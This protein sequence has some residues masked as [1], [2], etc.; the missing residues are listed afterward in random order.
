MSERTNNITDE[1]ITET[2]DR[3][4]AQHA[5]IT[6]T[7]AGQEVCGYPTGF[8]NIMEHAFL[9]R[10]SGLP[11][12]KDDYLNVYRTAQEKMGVDFI[13]QWIPDNPLTMQEDGYRDTELTAT[14]GAQQIVLDGMEIAGPEDVCDHMEKFYFPR[15]RAAIAAFDESARIRE[16]G[17]GEYLQ[18]QQMGEA[19]LKTGYSFVHFPTFHYTE[20]GYENYFCAYALEPA[21]MEQAFTLEADLAR[22]NNRAAAKAYERYHLPKLYRLDHDMT[23]SRGTLVNIRSMETLWFPQLYRALEPMLKTD[24]TMIWHCDGNIMP[25]IPYLLDCGIRGFQG[26]QYEDGVDFAKLCSLKAKDNTP[27]FI[28]GGSSVT[29]TLP[30]GTPEDVRK[31]LRYLVE[32]HGNSRLALGCSSSV[33]PGVPWENIQT[34]LEGLAYYRTHLS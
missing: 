25:M 23:D 5:R 20:Y 1:L 4:N 26:F 19:F 34:L 21:L 33:A 22:L 12:Y 30:M 7:I 18:Q 11:R 27:L 15:L 8:M 32:N 29:R 3:L 9:E 24:V 16:I 28:W 17:L 6:D 2:F 14:T 31:E 10:I 13:D